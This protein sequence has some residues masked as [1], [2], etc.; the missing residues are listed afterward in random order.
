MQPDDPET[1][2]GESAGLGDEWCGCRQPRATPT[3]SAQPCEPPP[4]IIATLSRRQRPIPT[5]SN[6]LLRQEVIDGQQGG[7]GEEPHGGG[8]AALDRG[9]VAAGGQVS[10][11]REVGAVAGVG[12]G[13]CQPDRQVCLTCPGRAHQQNVGG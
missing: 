4:P 10:S 6:R 9:A 7:S 12:G 2:I 11:G 5:S 3:F 8:P 1:I 13:P